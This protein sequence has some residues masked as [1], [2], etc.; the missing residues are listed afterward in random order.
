MFEKVE[1]DIQI[2]LIN[3]DIIKSKNELIK[4]EWMENIK[5]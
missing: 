2:N 4:Q 1:H 3:E 5:T